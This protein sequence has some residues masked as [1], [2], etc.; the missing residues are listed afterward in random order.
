MNYFSRITII[1]SKVA[2]GF[3]VSSRVLCYFIPKQPC[4][5]GIFIFPFQWE[6]KLGSER[7][8]AFSKDMEPINDKTKVCT[9]FSDS[10]FT[11]L[12]PQLTS[13]FF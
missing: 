10:K 11:T 13:L 12:L 2:L 9:R 5:V 7:L 1:T 3:K 4:H 6:R 8:S